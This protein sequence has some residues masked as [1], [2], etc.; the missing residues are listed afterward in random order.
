MKLHMLYKGR[1]K[2]LQPSRIWQELPRFPRGHSYR[3]GFA[4]D[5]SPPRAPALGE[6]I[7]TEKCCRTFA[8]SAELPAEVPL[9]TASFRI[10]LQPSSVH[11][12]E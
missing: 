3:V 10:H 8:F 6:Q 11:F 9:T 5:T 4:A 12:G 7:C 2:G 1:G